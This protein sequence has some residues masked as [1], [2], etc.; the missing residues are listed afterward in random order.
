MGWER[1][2][3]VARVCA[4]LPYGE[5][6][7][8]LGQKRFGQLRG[9]PT[10]RLVAQLEMA[11]WLNEYGAPVL[12]KTFVEVGTGH[13][14]VIPIGFYLAGAGQTVTVDLNRRIDWELTRQALDWFATH[15]AQVAALYGEAIVAKPVFAERLARLV[16]SR[17][18][19]RRFLEQ[20]GIAYLAP[21]DAANTGFPAQSVDCHYS[22]TVL[23]H[24]PESNLRD[25]LGEARRILK[26]DGLALHFI[27]PSDHFQHQD[28]SIT[29]INFL[30]F[31][32][33]EWRRLAGNQFAYCNRMRA[34]D[35]LRLIA[36]RGFVV[37]R[38]EPV[39][40]QQCKDILRQGF[41]VDSRFSRYAADDL[42]TTSLRVLLRQPGD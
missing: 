8:Q 20:A 19:P 22:M 41:A 31:S 35:F 5:K 29:P 40:D 21:K 26:P 25:I 30:Q 15:R 39:V 13:V 38:S 17:K 3:M 10:R 34:S 11:R 42:C 7:Y 12:G 36:E 27:D 28:R 37:A 24:I 6:L 33:E 18:N 32:D 14:P 2:A 23:E 4:Q 9:D 16:E 1:K